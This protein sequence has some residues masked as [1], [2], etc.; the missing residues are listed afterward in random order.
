MD[1]E[2][3]TMEEMKDKFKVSIPTIY[4]WMKNGLPYIRIKGKVRGIVRFDVQEV[5]EWVDQ[6]RSTEGD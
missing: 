6:N 3:L 2:L 1:M 4:K 5:M